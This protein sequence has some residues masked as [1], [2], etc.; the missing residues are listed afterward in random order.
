MG[1]RSTG[2]FPRVATWVDAETLFTATDTF[3]EV[4]NLQHSAEVH[5]VAYFSADA[6]G[7]VIVTTNNGYNVVLS[8]TDE[9]GVDLKVYKVRAGYE[10]GD[11]SVGG[12]QTPSV[13]VDFSGLTAGAAE[14]SVF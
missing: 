12:T 8:A 3:K 10:I 7:S 4:P 13:T 1:A 6:E 2:I 9:R 11:M 5:F 14:V